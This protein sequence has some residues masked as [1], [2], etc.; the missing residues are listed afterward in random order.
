[1]GLV[2]II[3]CLMALVGFI[4]FGFTQ[5]VCDTKGSRVKAGEV[6][7]EFLVINGRAY[8]LGNWTHPV[9]EPAFNGSTNPLYSETWQAGGKDASFL[10]QKVNENCQ[11]VFTP[12]PNSAIA[13]D[14]DRMGWYFPCNL[15]DANDQ[16]PVDKTGYDNATTCHT[17]GAARDALRDERIA[18]DVYYKWSQVKNTSR[19][20]AVYEK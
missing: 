9:A 20:L 4:T 18:G 5:T 17:S 6:P 14:G 3:L 12:A 11:G 19:N 1:M 7:T 15:H 2:S 13:S 16:S 10:F 8:D